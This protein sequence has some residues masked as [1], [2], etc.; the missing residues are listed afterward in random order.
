[1]INPWTDEHWNL[2]EQA[3]I[4][5]ELGE[6][7]ARRMAKEAGTTLGGPR[8]R[9]QRPMPGPPGP[10]GRI[11]LPGTGGGGGI[12]AEEAV[13]AVAAALAAGSHTGISISYNDPSNS[14]S[15]TVT[16]GG[17]TDEMV[18][19]RVAALLQSGTGLTWLYDDLLNALTPTVTV[20]QYTD[21]LAQD[22]AAAMIVAGTHVGIT[23][24]YS[25]VT[26][27][28]SLTSLA[29]GF[30]N[31]LAQDALALAFAAG[32]HTGITVTYDD[33]A[34]SFSFAS[35]ITQYTDEMARDAVG[36]MMTDGTT[37]DFTF[38]DGA[39][40][41]TGEVKAD[42]L[43]AG[44]LHAT[45]QNRLFGRTSASA[46]P[47]E[48][49]ILDTDG[50]LAANSD[51]RVAT[52]KALKTYVDQITAA[53]DAMI[54][55]GVQDCS[56]NPNYPA[57]DRGHTYRVSVAGKIGGASGINVEVGDMFICL[58]DGTASGT[59]AAQGTHWSITQANLDGAVI[60]PASAVSGQ[61]ASYSGTSGKLIQDSGLSLDTDVA[62][63]ANSDA[64]LPS[65]KA[66]KSYVDTG[67]AGKVTGPA[68]V[69]DDVPAVFDGTTGKLIK[70]KT[71]AAFTALLGV[72]SSVLAGVVP[73]SG[74]GTANFLRA[75][76]T[77]QPPPSGSSNGGTAEVDFGAFPGSTDCSVA[78]TGQG[79][80]VAG[81]KVFAALRL[82]ASADHSADEHMVENIEIFAGN[83][84]AGTGFTIYARESNVME[85][86]PTYT[87]GG[88]KI[89]GKWEISWSWV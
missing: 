10:R 69:T 59:Q 52:Q 24:A 88:P 54:F 14:L 7:V 65:Q 81:S 31:E 21:E 37:I 64:K 53:N 38:N 50:T 66:V 68:S 11:G 18:D 22:A 26:N 49:V 8:P 4:F 1:M 86:G 35:L 42:S 70:Q 84:V 76:G 58:D 80:I 30:T 40:T 32:S 36:A 25:D 33:T 9:K 27:A 79:G 44:F 43:T 78:V 12:T 73:A 51:L 77:W 15:L 39:D 56:G 87:P 72:F 47:G 41:I 23:V 13:D 5:R 85:Q 82:V 71:Y 61:L 45:A 16:G 55:K 63:A 46:G 6:E 17:Y 75:D 60:G 20:T 62:L 83:I 19:D 67:L 74:G 3:R 29:L 2:T 28:L 89:Y 48:E 34:N 57:A